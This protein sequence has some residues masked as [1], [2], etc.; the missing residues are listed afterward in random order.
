MKPMKWLALPLL[1]VAGPADARERGERA[2]ARREARL[3]RRH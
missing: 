1:L 2:E 3:D